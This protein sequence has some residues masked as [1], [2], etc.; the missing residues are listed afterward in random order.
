M[1]SRNCKTKNSDFRQG[2]ALIIAMIFMAVF[3][4][5]GLAMFTMSSGNMQVARIHLDGNR[6]L[7]S[8]ESGLDVLRYWLDNLTVSGKDLSSVAT[9]LNARLASSGVTNISASLDDP[10]N[11]ANLSIASVTL[12]SQTNQS[13]SAVISQID[14]ETLQLSVT[15]TNGSL[16]RQVN[17]NFSFGSRPSGI[18]D[19]GVATKGP[20]Y[21]TGN[22]SIHGVN[23]SAEANTYIESPYDNEA[24]DM[25]GDSQIAG[26]VSIANANA[27]VDLTGNCRIGGETGQSAID[28]NSC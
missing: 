13:F 22:V 5:F 3:S 23:N 9:A 16:S 4:S 12:N 7:E 24:L 10:Q 17:A 18:F 20:L 21:L 28:K 25:T 27:Y 26:D 1:K 6:A 19:F 15:G 2:A 8:A 14:T 11:P